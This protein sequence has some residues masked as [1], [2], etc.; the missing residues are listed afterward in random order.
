[1]PAGAI[2]TPRIR[3][4][5]IPCDCMKA[6]MIKSTPYKIITQ[7]ADWRFFNELKRELKT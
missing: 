2:T 6:G 7:G 4:V 3:S 1:M 5:S